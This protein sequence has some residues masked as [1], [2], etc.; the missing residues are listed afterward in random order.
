LSRMRSGCILMFIIR[1]SLPPWPPRKASAR[2]DL[3]IAKTAAGSRARQSVSAAEICIIAEACYRETLIHCLY[4]CNLH[5]AWN[6]HMLLLCSLSYYM[7]ASWTEIVNMWRIH[8]TQA[9]VSRM[10][11]ELSFQL[12]D[13][14][15]VVIL[16]VCGRSSE[17]VRDLT[18]HDICFVNGLFS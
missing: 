5:W 6:L 1:A 2:E 17:V 9:A 4:V 18:I 14:K 12:H 16:W 13:T 15:G 7:K 10:M 8:E 11:F 3:T